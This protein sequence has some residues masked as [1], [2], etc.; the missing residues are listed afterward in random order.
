MSVY[1][2]VYNNTFEPKSGIGVGGTR[3][4]PKDELALA[5]KI[6]IDNGIISYTK[7]KKLNPNKIFDPKVDAIINENFLEGFTNLM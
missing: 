7:W 4:A 3:S 2:I 6:S 5:T 1:N